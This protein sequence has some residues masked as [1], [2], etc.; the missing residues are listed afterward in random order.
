M[1]KMAKITNVK[2]PEGYLNAV[3]ADAWAYICRYLDPW[4][5]VNLSQTCR[6]AYRGVRKPYVMEKVAF[7]FKRQYKLTPEQFATLKDML[8]NGD[9]H[10]L[11]IGEVGSGKT[12]LATAYFMYKYREALEN[13]AIKVV[14]TVPPANLAQWCNFLTTY[15]DLPIASN[16]KGLSQL[17][18]SDEE[19]HRFPIYLTSLLKCRQ[20][21]FWFTLPGN[22]D[23]TGEEVFELPYV[24]IHDET[25]NASGLSNGEYVEYVGFTA[26][27]TTFYERQDRKCMKA[28][29]KF[30][31]ESKLLRENLPPIVY[32]T[33]EYCGFPNNHLP[34]IA[35]TLG[36]KTDGKF[37]ASQIAS[38]SMEVSYGKSTSYDLRCLIGRKTV[39]LER[40]FTGY[41]VLNAEEMS[42]VLFEVPKMRQL[43]ALCATVKDAGEKLVIFDT[44]ATYLSLIYVFLRHYNIEA[45]V[46]SQLYSASER[47]KQIEKFKQNGDVLIGS[48]SSLS[49]GHNIVEAVNVTFIRYP[50]NPE[51][52]NQAIGRVHR[53]PQTK[54]VKVHLL[55]SCELEGVLALKSMERGFSRINRSAIIEELQGAR[56]L[57]GPLPREYEHF[58]D[59]VDEME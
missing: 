2:A 43:L 47:P 27:E 23:N 53:Y 40:R 35:L 3:Y 12:W 37:S 16:Y 51:Q 33:Y 11:L 22:E 10:K 48:I 52:Y 15:T 44:D 58:V 18:V 19:L 45:Y 7:P 4:D 8:E 50:K 24:L 21:P 39:K 57:C 59:Q 46:F 28:W 34:Q 20:L 41:K 55:F 31:L 54:E 9:T 26:S 6:N 1:K 30:K 36:K 25:H 56:K 29:T 32:K 5:I 13:G 17:Y 14:I 49:E 38:F 42:A